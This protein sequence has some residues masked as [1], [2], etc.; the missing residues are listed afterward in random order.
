MPGRLLVKRAFWLLLAC[1]GHPMA[2]AD[3]PGL[4]GSPDHTGFVRTDLDRPLRLLWARE[5]SGERLG[6]AME[7]IVAG[8]KL[9]VATHSG[10]LYGCD[11]LSGV[12]LWRFKAE[13]PFLHSPAV[14]TN[15][16][17]IVASVEGSLY[18]ISATSGE[19][20]WKAFLGQ[21]GASA[22]PLVVGN[23]IFLGS[24]AGDFAC[25]R[26]ADGQEEWRVALGA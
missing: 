14:S 1:L 25:F 20:R 2:I 26:L 23:R 19:A 12:P 17:V 9:F 5:F 3:W 13:G 6:T 21:G 24:R 4:R 18:G 11:A 15:G 22:S 7:P 10:N 8:G 16:L